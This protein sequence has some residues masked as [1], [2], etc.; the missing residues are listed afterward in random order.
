MKKMLMGF[1][2]AFIISLSVVSAASS[3]SFELDG[4]SYLL[5]LNASYDDRADLILNGIKSTLSHIQNPHNDTGYQLHYIFPSTPEASFVLMDSSPGSASKAGYSN[6]TVGLEKIAR[7]NLSNYG[8]LATLILNGETLVIAVESIDMPRDKIVLSVNGANFPELGEESTSPY[9]ILRNQPVNGLR[10]IVREIK[11][12]N[13]EATLA[14]VN[15]IVFFEAKLRM[16]KED[17]NNEV[18][19]SSQSTNVAPIPKTIRCTEDLDCT[20][21]RSLIECSGDNLCTTSGSEKC[22]NPGTTSSYC[23][24]TSSSSCT[25]CPYGCENDACREKPAEKETGEINWWIVAGIVLVIIIIAVYFLRK[26]S[27]EQDF[28]TD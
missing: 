26:R 15:F 22:I 4:K 11:Y 8:E 6:I 17:I 2:F 18:I 5:K 1:V 12:A 28:M 20:Q 3:M 13:S 10:F 25:D 27:R 14:S 16:G 19:N 24:Q 21:P 23:N 7:V 9:N